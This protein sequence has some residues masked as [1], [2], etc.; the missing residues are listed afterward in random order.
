MPGKSFI[1]RQKT[2]HKFLFPPSPVGRRASVLLSLWLPS[3]FAISSADGRLFVSLIEFKS[4][5]NGDFQ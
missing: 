1:F 2:V 5:L 3:L 4:G